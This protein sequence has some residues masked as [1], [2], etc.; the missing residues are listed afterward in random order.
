MIIQVVKLL[1]KQSS[2]KK[3]KRTRQEASA[4]LESYLYYYRLVHATISYLPHILL[5]TTMC[6]EIIF[7]ILLPCSRPMMSHHVTC[8]VTV[9]SRAPLSLIKRKRKRKRNPKEKKYKIKKNR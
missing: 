3:H 2:G 9:M 4:K 7:Q 5:K 6:P 8:H 1:V